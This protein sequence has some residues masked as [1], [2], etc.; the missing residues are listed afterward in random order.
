MGGGLDSPIS[1]LYDSTWS[2]KHKSAHL[3]APARCPLVMDGH[4]SSRQVISRYTQP[5]QGVRKGVGLD[6][7]ISL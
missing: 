7:S 6:S 4:Q 5:S 3:G 1:P 2:R